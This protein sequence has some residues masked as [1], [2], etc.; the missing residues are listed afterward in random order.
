MAFAWIK[1]VEFVANRINDQCVLE[2]GF[3]GLVFFLVKMDMA[4]EVIR[5]FECFQ[6]PGDSFET[7]VN[8]GWA[9]MNTP[10]RRMG[11]KYIQVPVVSNFI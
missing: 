11:N 5:R 1:F 4:M 2:N 9:V 10:R 3:R 8:I 7:S 6:Q